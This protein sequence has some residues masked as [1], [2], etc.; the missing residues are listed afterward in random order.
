[1]GSRPLNVDHELKQNGFHPNI[2]YDYPDVE[3]YIPDSL[4]T[5]Y[6]KK[7]ETLIFFDTN[8]AYGITI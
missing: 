1:M 6:V 3:E 2:Y 7:I 5:A 8:H 4:P